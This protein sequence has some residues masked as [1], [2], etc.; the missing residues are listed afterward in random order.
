MYKII[1]TQGQGTFSGLSFSSLEEVK[2]ALQNYHSSDVEGAETMSL[3]TLCEIGGWSIAE[4]TLKT[5]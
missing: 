4:V 2:E 1:D 3:E 5:I